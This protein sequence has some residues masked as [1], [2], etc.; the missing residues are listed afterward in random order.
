MAGARLKKSTLAQTFL[1]DT[2]QGRDPKVPAWRNDR[3]PIVSAIGRNDETEEAVLFM[4]DATAIFKI[5]FD[6]GSAAEGNSHLH[7]GSYRDQVW[8]DIGCNTEGLGQQS[9]ATTIR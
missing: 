2:S 5:E 9:A 3:K 7:P 6:D 4:D 8:I 1:L